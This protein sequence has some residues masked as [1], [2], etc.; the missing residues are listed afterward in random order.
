MTSHRIIERIQWNSTERELERC[1]S[2]GKD[3][4]IVSD[5]HLLS[6]YNVRAL[7]VLPNRHWTTCKTARGIKHYRESPKAE[8]GSPTVSENGIEQNFSGCLSNE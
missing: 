8:K 7:G 3:S 5:D 6:T 4:L 1:L 2:S